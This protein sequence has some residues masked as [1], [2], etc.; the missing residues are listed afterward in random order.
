MNAQLAPQ[1]I[2]TETAHEGAR[3]LLRSVVITDL[4]DSTALVDRLGDVRA[5]ELI[6]THDRLLRGL[7]RENRGQ[8]IDKTDGFL[9]LFERPIQA[10]AFALAYQRGL[11]A[12]SLEHGVELKARIGLHVGEVM[13]WQNDLAD[14]AKGAKPTEVE[15]L[16]KPVA[17]RL[18]GMAL[19]GQILLSGVAYTLAHRAE[20]EL[21]AALSRVQWKAHG[22]F[23]FKG[24]AEAV[25]VY[26][27]G[28]ESIAPFKA[29][30]W[31][32]K[33]HRE[34]PLWRRPAMLTFEVLLLLVAIALPAWHFLK[35]EPAIAFAERD[36]VVLGDL[37]NL[38]GDPRFDDSLEQAFRIGLEQSRH[39]NV[40]SRLQVRDGLQRMQHAPDTTAIDRSLGAEL[41]LREGARALVIPTIAEIGGR[42]RFTAEIVDP[43]SQITVLAAS[44]DGS[45]AEAILGSVD[46]VNRVLRSGLGEALEAVTQDSKPLE[47]ASTAS[48]DALRAFSLAVEARF[49]NRIEDAL[50]LLDQAIRIDPE[51]ALAHMHR[52]L[53]QRDQGNREGSSAAYRKALEHLDRLSTADRLFTEASLSEIE[54]SPSETIERWRV[55]A[56]L[57][58]DQSTAASTYGFFAWSLG[59]DPVTGEAAYRKALEGTP[60][61]PRQGIA[62]YGLGA[63]LLAQDR[64]DEALQAFADYE[65]T[66]RRFENQLYAAAHAARRDY[67]SAEAA[68]ARGQ[69]STG[70]SRSLSNYGLRIAMAVDQGRFEEAKQIAASALADSE[71]AELRSQIAARGWSLTLTWLLDPESLEDRIA[72]EQRWISGHDLTGAAPAHAADVARYLSLLVVLSSEASDSF[73][74]SLHSRAEG[75]VGG[76]EYPE[77]RE[78]MRAA[79][80][81]ANCRGEEARP[82]AST[83]DPRPPYLH[84]W[85]ELLCA[86]RSGDAG[87]EARLAEQLIQRRGQ[88]YSEIHGNFL[89]WVANV[90]IS[91]LAELHLAEA[92]APGSRERADALARFL[93][94]WPRDVLSA[95]LQLRVDAL[96]QDADARVK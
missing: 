17:A 20:G 63:T 64:I 52:G 79:G 1:E 75:I 13:T 3:A 48:L 51:F 57:Y 24:V 16:A 45:S 84:G 46:E 15:G 89:T 36:W 96:K 22:D 43:T 44:A 94:A 5:T 28:E 70:P 49:Q 32:G 21:G 56:Q 27:I 86:R 68:L 25:P 10:V 41:A 42:L 81:A 67:A 65:K 37:R 61:G 39:V 66:E 7:I 59:N 85:A 60:S 54:G 38:T 40:V 83:A 62:F 87:S 34:V 50:A 82:V 73:A 35:P 33:A 74:R 69:Q 77:L 18:M 12:F 47:K 11:R 23:R 92:A 95:D 55:L 80:I 4:C 88:A 30:A 91:N 71:S 8:E 93:G 31:S 76:L 19:P 29:P 72:T 90:A 26:E 6:R 14:V 58:P 9:S 78:R 53:L 2:D